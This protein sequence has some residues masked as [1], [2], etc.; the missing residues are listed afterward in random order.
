MTNELKQLIETYRKESGFTNY[1]VEMIAE[2]YAVLV[3]E[4]TID[5]AIACVPD[6]TSRN[7]DGNRLETACCA[8]EISAKN[9]SEIIRYEDG[10]NSCRQQTISNLQALKSKE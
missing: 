1:D 6:K 9:W 10:H 4:Q 5:E 8:Y 7:Y 3:R 2:R